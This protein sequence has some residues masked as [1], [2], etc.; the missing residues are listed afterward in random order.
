MRK[1]TFILFLLIASSAW[2]FDIE[3]S[4]N[5]VTGN[6]TITGT[7]GD[8]SVLNGTFDTDVS[9][10]KGTGWTIDT[11]DSN[12]AIATATTG[13]L[14]ETASTV[15]AGKY[16]QLSFDAVV[17][18]GTF[19][20]LA[21]GWTSDTISATGAGMVR[22]FYATTTGAL[23]F[24][25]VSAFTG[26]IDNVTLKEVSATDL[27]DNVYVGTTETRQ[28][29]VFKRTLNRATGNQIAFHFAYETNKA[30][31]G[32]DTGLLIDVLD[33][34]S[35]GTS[36]PFEIR[37][38]GLTKLAYNLASNYLDLQGVTSI[39]NCVAIG[40]AGDTTFSVGG[41][42]GFTVANKTQVSIGGGVFSMT[43][44]VNVGNELANNF[45]A[46]TG[47]MDG[48]Y[49]STLIDPTYNETATGGSSEANNYDLVVSRIET[50]IGSGTQ[51][52]ASFGTGGKAAH[53]EGI[54]ISNKGHMLVDD[55]ITGSYPA[56]T[57]CGNSPTLTAGS[58]DFAGTFVIG[59]TGTGCV[60]TFGTA[61]TNVP[62]CIV[63]AETIANLTSYTKSASAITVVGV[64]GTFNYVCVGLNGG[65]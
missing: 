28:P 16:Y 17:T 14:N 13:N 2:G 27:L 51:R 56:L 59:A 6:Q 63:Q 38:G 29:I 40:R 18:S 31:S 11:G 39:T 41:G 45:G 24:D 43:S 25:G 57:S 20:V 1:F 36:Y 49:I 64:A 3:R 53:L 21:G 61:Y 42:N 52:L 60:I 10:T 4:M 50:A 12:N 46:P 62:S 8:N 34:A 9:W 35:P 32:N 26:T 47:N 7:L 22:Y 48:T 44:G 5:T 30:T 33:T 65:S 58:S 23:T 55:A 54:G 37:A 19:Q 15:V